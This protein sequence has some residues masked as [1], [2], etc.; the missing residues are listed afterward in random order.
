[1][2]VARRH[3]SAEHEIQISRP[4]AS[5][6]KTKLR[7]VKPNRRIAQKAHETTPGQQSISTSGQSNSGSRRRDM[8]KRDTKERWLTSDSA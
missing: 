5:G 7:V 1:M 4:K 3:Q 2:V 8:K 6:V